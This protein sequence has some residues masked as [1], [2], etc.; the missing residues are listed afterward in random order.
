MLVTSTRLLHTRRLLVT[1]LQS[2]ESPECADYL[3]GF[4]SFGTGLRYCSVWLLL[5][6]SADPSSH[7]RFFRYPVAAI[8]R[9]NRIATSEDSRS[10]W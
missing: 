6:F 7:G 3:A 10:E 1:S 5:F 2:P 8:A 9:Y 4:A